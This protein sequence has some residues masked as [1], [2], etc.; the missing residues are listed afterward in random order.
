[1]ALPRKVPPETLPAITV[2]INPDPKH[3][4]HLPADEDAKRYIKHPR[5]IT[6]FDQDGRAVWPQDQ[7]TTRRLRDG[8]ITLEAPKK[9]S[10]T[11][12][13]EQKSQ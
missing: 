7:F 10:A 8:D 5:A 3:W 4:P 1:M 9:G 12:K 11:H 6:Q 13:V 2:Y